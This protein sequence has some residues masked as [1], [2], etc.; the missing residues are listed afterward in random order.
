VTDKLAGLVLPD[1]T[2]VEQVPLET[3]PARGKKGNAAQAVPQ[4]AA[5]SLGQFKKSDW[6]LAAGGLALA[7][8]CAVFPWYIF[9]NQ[10]QFGIRPL[11]LSA[12]PTKFGSGSGLL[13]ELAREEMPL[14]VNKLPELDFFP[15]G[16]V[17]DA[18]ESEPAV[19]PSEQPF[20][21]DRRSFRFIHAE[22]GEA[23]I[24]DEDG[25][26]VVKRGSLLPGGSRVAGIE[27]RDGTWVLVTSEKTE[28][29]LSR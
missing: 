22:N 10:E 17:P 13:S 11:A 12:E 5:R 21:G 2:P 27:N 18:P 24:E 23:I 8:V 20:P 28:I 3:A 19:A 9:F 15:T 1:D 14:A 25:F 4:P 6:F 7:G 26:W 29:S 16:T